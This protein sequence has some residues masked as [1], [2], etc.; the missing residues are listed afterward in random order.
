[1]DLKTKI[2][3]KFNEIT[4]KVSGL[5]QE[6]MDRANQPKIITDGMP[7]LLR[8]A[9]ADG[10]VLF[11]ND[12]TLPLVNNETVSL[13]GRCQF[14]YFY[15]GYGSGGDVNRPYEIN[16]VDGIKKCDSLKLNTRLAS[17]Y[18]RFCF[19]NQE[20]EAMWGMWAFNREE[21]PVTSEMVSIAKSESDVAVVTIGRAAGEDRDMAAIKGS[22]YLT[23]EEHRIL[24]EVCNKFDK[25]VVLLNIGGVMD[26]SWAIEFGDKISAIL[27]VWQGGME[28]GNAVADLLCGKVNPSGR[29][30]D[31]FALEMNDYPSTKSF[32]DAKVDE[33][34]EDIFVGYRYFETFGADKVMYPFGFGLSYT[35]FKIKFKDAKAVD[36]GFEISA[37]VKNTGKVA[38]KEVVQLYL[39][40]PCGKLGNPAREL[41]AFA[42]TKE[43][44]P[45]KTQ[46]V[47]LRVD[48]Y[49]LCSYDDCGSTNHAGCWVIE[50]GEYTFHLGK[51]V[52]DTEPVF[53]YYQEETAV[54]CELK[55]AC[56]PQEDFDIFHAENLDGTVALRT[57]KV[58][59]QKYDLGVRI[60]NNLP[61]DIEQTGNM[62][63]KLIDVKNG[64]CTMEQFVAQLGLDE[65]EA[66]TRGDY[67]MDSPLGAKGNAGA[68]GGVLESLREKGIPAAITTD[69]PSGIR[70]MASCSLIPI[71]T[72]FACSYDLDLVEEVYGKVAD[73]M[74]DRGSDVLLAPGIN[75]HRH[76]LCGRN[77]EYYSE[78]PY[79]TGKMASAAVRGIQKNGASACPKHFACN[80]QEFKRNMCDSRVSERA[81]REI[82]LRGFEICV[83]EAEPKNI[84]TS[85]NKLNGVYCHYNY[86]LATTIL[87]NQWGYK[88]N[89]ITDWWMKS[90]KSPDFPK[91]KDQAYRVRA[92]VDVFMPGGDRVTNGKPD[93][94]LL[95]TYDKP[96]GITLGEMQSCA[97]HI[98]NFIM[99]IKL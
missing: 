69:G 3:N 65:L 93:G 72:L 6:K 96:E 62:G 94:T 23:D 51:N 25:V 30:T 43:L 83:N 75:V 40:K 20:V 97:I 99:D 59:K 11:K 32:G 36:G 77:F 38:G 8:R 4:M 49:Q 90:D 14:D 60:M 7:E 73:E 85:Y 33:Y 92:G 13:F 88:G 78:D 91:I 28:S 56:A 2:R 48:E 15:V 9:A 53:T 95:A 29:L 86:D 12:G 57:R 47:H 50:N 5:S 16:L 45:N 66:I 42:K 27:C 18:E 58:A 70:L 61:A 34:T 46:T 39:E 17:I 22:Y 37:T 10:A 89:V 76:P 44:E 31:T 54:V 98:L 80:N 24:T 41:V 21:M 1:M 79:L 63:Y 55:Q 81:L 87:R 19:E 52:K 82:Y 68:F 74:K 64:K 71:G 35:D 67:K 84:M 26:M